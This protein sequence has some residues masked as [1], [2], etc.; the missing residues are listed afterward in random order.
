MYIYIYLYE[1]R[2]LHA[3]RR[4]STQRNILRLQHTSKMAFMGINRTR[5]LR[6][7]STLAQVWSRSAARFSSAKTVDAATPPAPQPPLR[8]PPPPVSSVSPP[9][10]KQTTTNDKNIKHQCYDSIK[11]LLS[12]H[13]F[14]VCFCFRPPKTIAYP[15]NLANFERPYHYSSSCCL[16]SLSPNQL[17]G[18]V[19]R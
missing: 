2:R 6:C 17:P 16:L 13:L 7:S 12:R 5:T 19:L 18:Q 14:D 1:T 4:G 15:S 8:T 11:L 9:A 10:A 3:L